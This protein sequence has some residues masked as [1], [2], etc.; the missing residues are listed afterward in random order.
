MTAYHTVIEDNYRL[1]AKLCIYNIDSILLNPLKKGVKIVTTNPYYK[2]AVD[3]FHYIRRESPD[4]AIVTSET[5]LNPLKSG[6]E[7]KK[8]GNEY[9]KAESYE[10]AISCYTL[11]IDIDKVNSVYWSNRAQCYIK[12]EHFER[13]LSDAETAAKLNI[14][15]EKIQFRMAASWS[16]LGDHEKSCE[17]LQIS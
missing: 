5:R 3:G 11:T 6:D 15:A 1:C 8:E 13:A 7:Y 14:T 9:Y 2:Q 17:I 12:L 16:G 10:K 4:E